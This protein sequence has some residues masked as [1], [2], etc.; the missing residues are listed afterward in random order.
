MHREAR[1]L[2]GAMSVFCELVAWIFLTVGAAPGPVQ[3][4]RFAWLSDTHVGSP[5]G[6][7]DLQA[8]V[9]DINSR[10]DIA[11]VVLSGD[12]TEMGSDAELEQARNILARLEKPYHIIPGNHDTKWSESGCT[13]FARIFGN[14]RFVFHYGGYRFIGLHQGPV[15]KMG[16]GHFA[17]EDLRWLDSELA[18]LAD[19]AQ[20]VVVVTHYPPDASVDNWFA[21][22][23]RIK[24]YNTQAV[25]VGHGHRN[26]AMDFEGVP[27]IMARSVLRTGAAPSGYTIVEVRPDAMLFFERL[28]GSQDG[29]AWH[30]VPL[31][32]RDYSADATAY[33]RPD[34]SVN[35]AYPNVRVRWKVDT[36]YTI[37]STPAVWKDY[38][39]VGNAAGTVYGVSLKDGRTHWTFAAGSKVFATPA[40]ADG[41]VVFGATDSHVYCLEIRSGNLM[42]KLP[43]GAP[44][45]GGATIER[46][47][48][49]IG[50]SDRAF[51]AIDLRTGSVKWKYAGIGGFIETKPLI[52]QGKVV[53]GAWDSSLYAL[54]AKDGSPA[55]KWSGG[56]P[57][58]LYSPAACW[59]V[60]AK[61]KIFVVA[62]DR[63]MTA[64]DA[65]TGTTVW[66]SNLYEVREAVGIST[67]GSRVYARTM[68][69]VVVALS[70]SAASPQPV[71]TANCGYGY[72]IDPS[73]PVEKDGAVFFGTKNGTVY[74]LD[75]RTGAV[76]W[77][78]RIGVTA[79]HTP[80]PLD[81][82]RVLVTDSDGR[83]MLLVADDERR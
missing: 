3:P 17:P 13:S 24:R 63:Y 66:R 50:G 58:V 61:G 20:P 10:Q 71:W 54:N 21:L 56:R 62:P 2:A 73:M 14:D 45:V 35:D 4:F 8:A 74:A 82:R 79:V 26:R 29:P 47:A 43:S 65:Q 32:R 7:E 22:I 38:A 51:R 70:A 19:R 39:V 36:G 5:T 81:R 64:V 9:S 83:I 80:V 55:W 76:R 11:F 37:A 27:G 28:P 31:L 77:K 30:S 18:R 72:D 34:Y 42:W 33:P 23:D 15:M 59:P 16:D 60:G 6:A 25:L 75:G 49:Y 40:A 52:Y 67:D 53:F 46:D 1:L 12:I 44:V 41:R 68:N 57:G 69:D 48:V 78:Y